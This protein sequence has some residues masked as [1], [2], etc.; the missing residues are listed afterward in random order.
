MRCVVHAHPPTLYH[1]PRHT[2]DA[3]LLCLFVLVVLFHL[4]VWFCRVVFV[5]A[6]LLDKI[7]A[8]SVDALWATDAWINW[9]RIG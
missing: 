6:S 8:A 2:Y 9:M 4:F 3:A 5:L 7:L 1:N